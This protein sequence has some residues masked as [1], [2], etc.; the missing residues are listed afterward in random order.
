MQQVIMIV[1]YPASGKSTIAKAFVNMGFEYLNR[2]SAGGKVADLVPMLDSLL[3]QGKRVIID[4][5]HPTVESRKPFIDVACKHSVQIDCHWLQTSIEDAQFNACMRMMD[6]H[7]KILCADEMKSIKDPNIFP[8]VV[9][10]KYKKQFEKPTLAEG[11]DF[12]VEIPFD[13][14]FPKDWTG[15]AII[16]DYDDTL[17][18]SIGEKKWPIQVKDVEL[19]PNRTEILKAYLVKG[20]QL[21]GASNQSGIAKNYPT[22]DIAVACF[23]KT[24]ELLGIDID[25][26]YCPHRVPPISCYCRKPM[27]GMA[28]ERFFNHKLDPRE[29]IMVGDSTSDKTFAKRSHMKFVHADEF[30]KATALV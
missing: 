9:L 23:D 5:T 29:C 12:V 1:G 28:V 8:P 27:P 26:S 4:N 17:R 20:Y 13:R 19:L 18:T 10:F 25:V 11:F 24:N 14:I 22:E 3:A 15:K 21:F 30:F 6:R 7:G 16:F 2:D